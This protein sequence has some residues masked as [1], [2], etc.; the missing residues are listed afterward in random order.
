MLRPSTRQ[1][2]VL[3]LALALSAGTGI[4]L[5]APAVLSPSRASPSTS[6]RIDSEQSR[7][8]TPTVQARP[9]TA[10]EGS[11]PVTTAVPPQPEVPAREVTLEEATAIAA[12][13]APGRVV[14]TDLDTGATGPEYEITLVHPDGTA[15]EIGVDARTG[16]VVSSKLHDEWD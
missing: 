13:V 8:G 5:A 14:E 1:Q 7:A 2:R 16:Q 9:A 15:S 10:P 6:D 4:G 3:G 11:P 12:R